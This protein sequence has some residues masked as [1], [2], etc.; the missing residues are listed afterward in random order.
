VYRAG[1]FRAGKAY[2]LRWPLEGTPSPDAGWY[3]TLRSKSDDYEI[4]SRAKRSRVEQQRQDKGDLV[5]V[6]SIP[7]KSRGLL[8][9]SHFGQDP[10][11]SGASVRT[12]TM[13]PTMGMEI[14]MCRE[15][16]TLSNTVNG[17]RHMLV[18]LDV[19]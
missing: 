8:R 13:R 14:H 19:I 9:Q 7:A 5:R 6:R 17:Y 18:R 12:V 3:G 4:E 11:S 10:E 16:K 15:S 1:L 2:M